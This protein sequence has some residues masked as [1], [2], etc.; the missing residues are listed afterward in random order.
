[1]ITLKAFCGYSGEYKISG[2]VLIFYAKKATYLEV[3][4]NYEEWDPGWEVPFKDWGKGTKMNTI[5]FEEPLVFKFP[6]SAVENKA[7]KFWDE[8][9]IRNT[10]TIG[11]SEAYQ[12]LTDPNKY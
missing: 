11:S 5:I 9:L 8:E 4:P 10:V 6:L 2:N 3:V 12:I 7:V 1:M